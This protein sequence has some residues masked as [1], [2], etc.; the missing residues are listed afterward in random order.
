MQPTNATSGG[1][2][3]PLE[4]LPMCYG[5]NRGSVRINMQ[6]FIQRRGYKHAWF[7]KQQ[8]DMNEARQRVFLGQAWVIDLQTRAI[9][10]TGANSIQDRVR[11]TGNPIYTG[12]NQRTGRQARQN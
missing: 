5:W 9:V 3:L 1:C 12:E 8:T 7:N 10:Q 6:S 4:K 2:S 11:Q